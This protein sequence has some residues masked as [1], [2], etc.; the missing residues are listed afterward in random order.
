VEGEWDRR[1]LCDTASSVRVG[2]FI[3]RAVRYCSPTGMIGFV[4]EERTA[5]QNPDLDVS[6]DNPSSVYAKET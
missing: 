1:R 3:S 4:I 2:S 6:T 5:E